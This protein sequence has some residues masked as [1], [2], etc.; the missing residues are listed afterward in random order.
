MAIKNR[1]LFEVWVSAEKSGR[2]RA[3]LTKILSCINTSEDCQ[4]LEKEYDKVAHFFCLLMGRKWQK[5]ARIRD[6]FLHDYEDWLEEEIYITEA[7]RSRIEHPTTIQNSVS[8]S[9]RRRPRLPFQECSVKTK[10]KA[11]RTFGQKLQ[12]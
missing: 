11:S 6:R 12:L 9:S 3:V 2:Q 8:G 1:D 5:C 7:L 4:Y 10:K